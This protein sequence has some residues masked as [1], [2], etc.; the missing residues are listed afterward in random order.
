MPNVRRPN[1][2][3]GGWGYWHQPTQ[4]SPIMRPRP[5][6]LTHDT[7]S[8]SLVRTDNN[9]A[10]RASAVSMLVCRGV[11]DAHGDWLGP[12]SAIQEEQDWSEKH[13]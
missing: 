7:C 4:A 2:A 8:P 11:L 3:G 13:E 10:K 5:P 9:G 6:T 1:C 12:S